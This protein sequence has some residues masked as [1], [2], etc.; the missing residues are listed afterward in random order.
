MTTSDLY[1]IHDQKNVIIT[2]KSDTHWIFEVK[3]NGVLR[4]DFLQLEKSLKIDVLLQGSGASCFLNCAYLLNKNKKINIDFDIKHNAPKT[5]S[6]QQIK[7]IVTDRSN[8]SFQGVIEIPKSSQ[9]CDGKQHHR[10]IVLSP[11]AAVNAIPQ[12]E[13][14]ADDVICSHGSAIGP[15]DPNELFYM[16]TRGLTNAAARR[17]LLSSFLS[18]MMPSEFSKTIQQWMDENA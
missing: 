17:L 14:W 5:T 11:E 15:L 1:I 16:Q 10:A 6:S 2:Q 7:G 13:I 8:A 12:L 3:R 18:D 4:A 9:K